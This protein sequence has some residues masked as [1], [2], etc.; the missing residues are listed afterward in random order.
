MPEQTTTMTH[1]AA[2]QFLARA[3]FAVD[4]LYCVDEPDGRVLIIR[5]TRCAENIAAHGG[6]PESDMDAYRR[7]V[8]STGPVDCQP[9]T[10]DELTEGRTQLAE[11]TQSINP[12]SED[13]ADALE[14]LGTLQ[15]LSQPAT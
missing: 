1:A 12:D 3:A 8:F 14:A 2:I 13:F 9:L 6:L 4:Q 5:L 11:L 10:D 15:E 7:I